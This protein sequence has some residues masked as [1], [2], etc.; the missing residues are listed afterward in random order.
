MQNKKLRLNE[1]KI[2]SFVTTLESS[3]INY[4]KGGGTETLVIPMLEVSIVLAVSLI[5]QAA[6]N[7]VKDTP[8]DANSSENGSVK[9]NKK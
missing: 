7:D 4:V 6:G 3:K 9:K 8:T 1:L 2:D 5:I